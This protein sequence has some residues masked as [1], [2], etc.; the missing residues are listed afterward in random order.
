[1]AYEANRRVETSARTFAIVEHLSDTG[2]VGVSTV[3]ESLSMS[4]GIV[5]N[6]LSTLRELGY[7]TK[8]GDRYQLSPKFLQTGVRSRANTPLYRNADDVLTEFAERFDLGV[9]LYQ[10]AGN[11]CCVVD[12]Y[13]LSPTL[14][15]DAGVSVPLSES[16]A[17]LVLLV[18]SGEAGSQQAGAYD[19]EAVAVALDHH[20]YAVGSLT[21]ENDRDCVAFPVTD[22][23]GDCHG[24][25]SVVLP[26]G[27]HEQQT[28][29]LIASLRERIEDR[30]RSGWTNERSFAT[31]KH[32]WVGG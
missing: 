17:G 2:P 20:G 28:T 13:H 24:S 9:A 21:A 29:A 6:H 25:V 10:R 26:D 7:V 1:M 27:E 5:H 14:G 23:D 8:V 4:K 3:A 31:E 12:S 32:S 11:D 19:A 15:I 18:E 30:F 22:E 16:L